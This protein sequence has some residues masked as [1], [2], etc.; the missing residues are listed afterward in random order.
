M[1]DKAD[2]ICDFKL[3]DSI[4]HEIKA[5]NQIV[6]RQMIASAAKAG[7]DRVT[8][9]HGWIIAYL[10][11]RKN[12]DVFQKDIETEFAISRSTVTN[13]LKLMEKKGYIKRVS[14]ES[15][16]RLKK[17]ELTDIGLD[18]NNKIRDTVIENEN[19]LNSA[20]TDN[21]REQLI[22]LIKK[23]RRNLKGENND[24]DFS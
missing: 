12:K 2:D 6:Q 19:R 21:E 7:L 20:L 1:C 8:V 23:L 14:V 24:K 22:N 9:M 3:R 13:I 17:I 18:I 16:A 11:A 10:F 4:G 15:D 5:I